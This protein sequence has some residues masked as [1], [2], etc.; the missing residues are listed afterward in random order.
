MDNEE[1][2]K[3]LIIESLRSATKNWTYNSSPTDKAVKS[4]FVPHKDAIDAV[5][6]ER[7]SILI[8][9]K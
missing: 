2:I 7:D 3:T 1:Y 4:T 8:E 6:T 9:T 5:F